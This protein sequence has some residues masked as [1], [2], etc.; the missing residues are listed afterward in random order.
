MFATEIVKKYRQ[1]NI[2]QR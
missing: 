2:L 1:K